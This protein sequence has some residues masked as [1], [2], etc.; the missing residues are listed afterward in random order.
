MVLSVEESNQ[1]NWVVIGQNYA[2][3]AT[4]FVP[5]KATWALGALFFI[6]AVSATNEVAP[7]WSCS[8]ESEILP[9]HECLLSVEETEHKEFCDKLIQTRDTSCS[10]STKMCQAAT[11]EH[12]LKCIAGRRQ[13][14][15][16]APS[17]K[18]DVAV[19]GDDIPDPVTLGAGFDT[20][21]AKIT[22]CSASNNQ[23]GYNCNSAYDGVLTGTQGWAYSA[24]IPAWA[25]FNLEAQH[26]V[27]GLDLLSGVERGD[28]RLK[29]FK[30]TLKS[31]GNFIESSNMK[32]PNAAG[33]SI[34]GATIEMQNYQDLLKVT[35]DPVAGVTAVRIDVYSTDASNNNG[36][37]VDRV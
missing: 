11:S 15:E 10:L 36:L 29:K 5:T 12:A 24:Q 27:A 17:L 2:A 25:I 26:T 18:Q 9:Q 1:M 34:S 3:S 8:S 23:G 7:H 21:S 32:V 33:A 16:Y 13:Q 28:H 14:W 6:A 30:I 31:S 37:F 35:F 19:G 22:S 4:K 20:G